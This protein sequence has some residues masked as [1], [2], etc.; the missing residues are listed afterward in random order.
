M[1][2]Y[3]LGEAASV[4]FGTVPFWHVSAPPRGVRRPVEPGETYDVAIV[5]GG[6]TGL[7]TAK[8]LLDRADGARI[9]IFEA[10]DI[11]YGASG[12]NAGV[13][14][15]WMG[16]SPGSLLKLGADVGR[17]IHRD[18]VQSVRDVVDYITTNAIECDL[19]EVSLLYVSSNAANDRRIR[20]DLD[21][22]AA[23]GDEVYKELSGEEL[24][25]RI[26]SPRLSSGF[27]DTVAATE[28]PAK[29][30]RGLADHLVARGVDLFELAP[31][32]AIEVDDR[33]TLNTAAGPVYAERVVLA[34]NAW[35]AGDE[36]FRRRLLP[37]YVY[38]VITE[39]LSDAQWE[40]LG[41]DGR[42]PVNDRRFFLINYRRTPDG[43]LMFGGV[44][45]R[46]P[47]GGRIQPDLDRV[48]DVFGAQRA[49]LTRVFPSLADV[50]I[51]FG[52]G[53]PIAMTPS[54]LPQVG[55]LCGGR[56]GYSHG[57]C[58]HGVAES[59]LCTGI[60]VD[61]LL[62]ERTERSRY[63]FV[64]PTDR[65]YPREPLRWIGGRVTRAEGLWFDAAGDAGR[66]TA[67]EPRLLKAVGRLLS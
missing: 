44:D 60:L 56:V 6:F 63:P 39:P 38:D 18:A 20:R 24:R 19:D 16:H 37:F 50:R 12:R 52:H 7:W 2:T 34:R 10:H 53:G 35:A 29:L 45:G 8:H 58:G 22:A 27:E 66:S 9:A 25:R 15:N 21:A 5:G 47:F 13:L 26:A 64:D 23:I 48:G 41:W 31:V 11:G 28:N 17:A 30:V 36:P 32:S 4:G 54:L 1:T 57:Y 67:E 49:A 43:R 61:L 46:Q 51:T 3:H 65:R 55:L 42:E 14:T 40:R 59:H 33:V 62:G